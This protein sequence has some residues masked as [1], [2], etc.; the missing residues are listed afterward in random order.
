MSTIERITKEMRF[1]SASDDAAEFITGV[2][3]DS[4]P[5]VREG[6]KLSKQSW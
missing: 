5:T 6:A 4:S 2:K 1:I 3:R